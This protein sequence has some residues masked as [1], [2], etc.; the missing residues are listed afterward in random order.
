M[1]FSGEDIVKRLDD[2]LKNKNEK[3]KAV[4]DYAGISTQT[5]T[6][7]TKRGSIPAADTLYKIADYLGYTVE[8]LLTGGPPKTHSPEI[9][10]I[11]RKI[12]KLSI[13]DKKE[14]V[15]LLDYKLWVDQQEEELEQYR[16]APKGPE[17]EEMEIV[18]RLEAESP[19]YGDSV[20]KNVIYLDKAAIEEIPLLGSTAAGRPINFG[21]LDPDPP[22][23]PWAA[24]L[25]RGDPDNYY[26]V[27]IRGDSMTQAD[28]KDGDYALLRRAD[29]AENGE[30]MLVRHDNSSTLKR[31]KVTE[32]KGGREETY[33]CWEDGS[34]HTEKL[35]GNH[36]IQGRL[37]A[38]ERK[39]GK[40]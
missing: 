33:I 36:E 10:E 12:A 8:Y 2:I 18:N 4:C 3:R 5:I 28:I 21:D 37:V 35:G 20:F 38:I 24:D 40:R 17:D 7:W 22:T 39:P 16:N 34:G 6:D 25:I 11:A 15:I 23:R 1:D 32:G 27:L 29:G 30:I 31:I 19:V 13:I 26:C 9:L 14:I